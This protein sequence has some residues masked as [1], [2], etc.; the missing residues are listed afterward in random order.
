M[1]QFEED[2]E[3]AKNISTILKSLYDGKFDSELTK[4]FS[5]SNL[6]TFKTP[7]G[8]IHFSSTEEIYIAS[9]IWSGIDTTTIQIQMNSDVIILES[10][11]DRKSVV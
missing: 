2:L 11:K 8:T 3:L 7:K 4:F 1:T 10:N 6:L 5:N 9:A